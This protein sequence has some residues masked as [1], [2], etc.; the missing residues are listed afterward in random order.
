MYILSLEQKLKKTFSSRPSVGLWVKISFSILSAVHKFI[1]I[2][3]VWGIRWKDI[4]STAHMKEKWSPGN[5][6]VWTHWLEAFPTFIVLKIVGDQDDG[7]QS[8]MQ[9]PVPQSS[10]L[11]CARGP[12]EEQQMWKLQC[13]IRKYAFTFL[14]I[15]I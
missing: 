4:F 6:F 3:F 13:F 7:N 1:R 10:P 5:E 8:A 14:C 11:S 15:R 12:I 2:F 9:G